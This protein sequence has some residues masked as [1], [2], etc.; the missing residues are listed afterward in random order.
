MIAEELESIAQS[1][2]VAEKARTAAN[3]AFGH[4]RD[5]F[6]HSSKV[7]SD[8]A[9]K[10]WLEQIYNVFEEEISYRNDNATSEYTANVDFLVQLRNKIV[11]TE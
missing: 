4:E 2:P 5:H 9:T 8:A 11:G 7:A 3:E 1:S 10:T 6:I